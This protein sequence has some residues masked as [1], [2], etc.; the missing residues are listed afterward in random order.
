MARHEKRIDEV[1][2]TIKASREVIYRAFTDRD[3]LLE[4]LPPKGMTAAFDHFDARV[5]GGY[6]MT[7]TYSNADQAGGKSSTTTD[8]VKALFVALEEDQRVVQDVTFESDK[9]EFAGTMQ[10]TWAV[11]DGGDATTV[12]FTAEDVPEGITKEDHLEGLSASL[13]NLAKLVE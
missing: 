13:E 7:L 1:S 4:W 10:M 11:A 3:A 9:P 5:G 2:R 6:R 8:V 12:T